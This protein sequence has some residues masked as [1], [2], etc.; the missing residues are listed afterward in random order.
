[1]AGL[2]SPHQLDHPTALAAAVL[3]DD[4]RLL[5][6]VIGIVALAALAV[7]GVL[8]RQVLAAGEGTDRM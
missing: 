1:M 6:V 8:V 2:S 4:N 5:V 3:T 7:A